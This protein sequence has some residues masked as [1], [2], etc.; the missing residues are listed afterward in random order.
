M[1]LLGRALAGSVAGAGEGMQ[2]VGERKASAAIEK[3]RQLREDNLARIRAAQ[4]HGMRIDLAETE[5]GWRQDDNKSLLEQQRSLAE[6]EA[7]RRAGEVTKY[8]DTEQGIVGLTRSGDAVETG[9]RSPQKEG[10]GKPSQNRLDKSDYEVLNN[11]FAQ[12]L[13]GYLPEEAKANIPPGEAPSFE[14]I[15]Q[16]LPDDIRNKALAAYQDAEYLVTDGG[17]GYGNAVS[18]AL[19][20]RMGQSAKPAPSPA[21]VPTRE[22]ILA[23]LRSVAPEDMPRKAA[24][25]NNKY[26]SLEVQRILEEELDRI[27]EAPPASKGKR[28][29]PEGDPRKSEAYRK[30]ADNPPVP[31]QEKASFNIFGG[32]LGEDPEYQRRVEE[33]RRRSE[34]NKKRLNIQ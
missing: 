2:S 9:Y 31:Q 14:V 32:L 15:M 23:E 34:E 29:Q 16:Y 1:G 27:R 5:R 4:Q 6:E 20:N 24:Q 8:M 21:E 3:A 18:V 33:A 28:E 25:I 7:A 19:K 12:H 10:K 26:Q 17:R 30:W 13:I 22:Q 11:T